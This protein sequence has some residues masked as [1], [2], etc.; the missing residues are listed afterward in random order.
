VLHEAKAIDMAYKLAVEEIPLSQSQHMQIPRQIMQVPDGPKIFC[1]A[2]VC[3]QQNSN[4]A[5][6]GIR[7]FILISPT[8]SLCSGIFFQVAVRRA[9]Q[10][11]EVE[12]W[13]LLLEAKL[14]IA[15]NLQGLVF[16]TDNETLATAANRR[17]I[18]HDPGHWTLR[19]I[20]AECTCVT[21]NLHHSVIKIGRATNKVADKFAKKAR[22]AVI[23]NSCCFSYECLVHSRN[24]II[25]FNLENFQWARSAPSGHLP[26]LSLSNE[27]FTLSKKKLSSRAD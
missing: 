25:Q 21:E 4:A 1:D 20:L 7:I 27:N 22:H 11:L 23:P 9:L 15:L 24:C 26:A 5:Q 8:H 17:T 18:I 6:T 19:P 10:P 2:S 12:A 3:V 13:A 16:L 14:T